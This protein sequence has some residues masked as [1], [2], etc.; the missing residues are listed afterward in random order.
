[1]TQ[2]TAAVPQS[3]LQIM[4]ST[5]GS[6]FA[7]KSGSGIS[8]QH[9]GEEQLSGSQNT[10]DGVAPVVTAGGK[11]TMATI[12]VRGL[13]TKTSGEFWDYIRDL[14]EAG[15]GVYIRWAPEGGIGTVVGNEQ[16]TASDDA[17][18]AFECVIKTLNT[19]DLDAGNGGPALV[20]CVLECPKVVRATTTT[21]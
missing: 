14:H 20:S 16:F 19:P 18:T 12:T 11:R 15:S 21:A 8:I 13:Y 7:D 9:T 3:G 2:S 4:L 10:A 5:D 6:T 17:G 1:M